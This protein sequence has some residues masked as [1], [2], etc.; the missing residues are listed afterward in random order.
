MGKRNKRLLAGNKKWRMCLLAT[1]LIISAAVVWS[2]YSSSLVQQVNL[3]FEN[4][5]K[6]YDEKMSKLVND[7]MEGKVSSEELS[8]RLAEVSDEF[9]YY[10]KRDPE[11]KG[12]FILTNGDVMDIVKYIDK[13]DSLNESTKIEEDGQVRGG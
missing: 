12:V 7:V 6:D 10:Y 5:S 3:D 9:V 1:V 8:K 4:I 2:V 13:N 11:S